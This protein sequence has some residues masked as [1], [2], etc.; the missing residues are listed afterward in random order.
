MY[1]VKLQLNLA[2]RLFVV[3][4][5]DITAKNF[6][7]TKT[8]YKCIHIFVVEILV[9]YRTYIGLQKFQNFIYQFIDGGDRS[10]GKKTST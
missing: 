7:P 2:N 6:N 3:C 10:T 5:V 4:S 9:I 1:S 8:V